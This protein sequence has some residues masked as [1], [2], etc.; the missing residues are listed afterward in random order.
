MNILEFEEYLSGGMEL[1]DNEKF[2]IKEWVKKYE[3]YFNLYDTEKFKGSVDGLTDDCL[4][5]I[6]INQE[7]RQGVKKYIQELYKLSDGLSVVM[8][9]D[10]QFQYTNIDQVQRFQY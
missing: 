3:K 9:P 10:M 6:S 1:R 4:N 5:Q 2:L 8:A 7:K